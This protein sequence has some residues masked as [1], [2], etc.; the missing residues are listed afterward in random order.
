MFRHIFVT[1]F[2]TIF[3]AGSCNL[4]LD[5]LTNAPCKHV[6]LFIAIKIQERE[7]ILKKR[8]EHKDKIS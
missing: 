4:E 5:R 8:K 2:V 1:F 7:K 3:V 6:C